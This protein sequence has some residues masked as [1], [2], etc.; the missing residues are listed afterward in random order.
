MLATIL[1]NATALFTR[2]RKTNSI[3][4]AAAPS[5]NRQDMLV[6]LHQHILHTFT[7]IIGIVSNT[8]ELM[9]EAIRRQDIIAICRIDRELQRQV[10]NLKDTID[11][12][13]EC[14][15]SVPNAD[16]TVTKLLRM[17]NNA[18]DVLDGFSRFVEL[19]HFRMAKTSSPFSI[20]DEDEALSL[21]AKSAD[22]LKN[23]QN[24][25]INPETLQ[26]LWMQCESLD[27][28]TRRQFTR[29]SSDSFNDDNPT[30]FYLTFLQ[31]LSGIMKGIKQ[32]VKQLIPVNDNTFIYT[33]K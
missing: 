24:P 26:T 5:S 25:S 18:T 29:T 12:E 33:R 15:A 3:M 6:I 14:L 7:D 21:L 32:C 1:S 16:E 4:L 8:F 10:E 30:G 13:M 19:V 27:C 31:S 2:R 23:L 22:I 28:I 17:E 9:N 20:M 11:N